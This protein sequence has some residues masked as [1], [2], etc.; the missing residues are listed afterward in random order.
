MIISGND[1]S[2]RETD[3]I[4]NVDVAFKID[5]VR[6]VKGLFSAIYD[7]VDD[8]DETRADRLAWYIGGQLLAN[9][10]AGLIKSDGYSVVNEVMHTAN[11]SE[12]DVAALALDGNSLYIG[13][14]A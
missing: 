3:F 1:Y 13:G 14:L 4:G 9:G 2:K 5:E 10:K 8:G 6:G 7:L 11:G 12:Y